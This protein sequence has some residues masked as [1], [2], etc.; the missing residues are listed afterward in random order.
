MIKKMRLQG[1]AD[2]EAVNRYLDEQYRPE[3]NAKFACE[4]SAGADFHRR[5]SKRLDLK[6]VFCLEAERVVSN[7]LVV[8]F[9]NRFLQLKPKRNQALGAGARVTVQQA[10]EGKLQVLH[11]GRAVAFEEI[12]RPRPKLPPEPKQRAAPQRTKPS[13]DHPWRQSLRSKKRAA[14]TYKGQGYG[15]DGPDGKRGN[16]QRA[17]K[18]VRIAT[19]GFPP[20]P[21]SLGNRSRDAHIPTAPTTILYLRTYKQRTKGI[22]PLGYRGGHFYWALTWTR[23]PFDKTRF[24]AYAT[25]RCEI[26]ASLTQ[27]RCCLRWRCS[28]CPVARC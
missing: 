25:Y 10:R 21:P 8:R 6:W 16:P 27:R 2:Y 26:P 24:R 19:T 12:V 17:A 28:V 13:A 9:E 22:F 7:D 4:P 11:E 23:V 15:N 1:I 3:H 20:F 18:R 14:T 5:L